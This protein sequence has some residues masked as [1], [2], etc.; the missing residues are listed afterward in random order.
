[1]WI[2]FSRGL[3]GQEV[4]Q[5]VAGGV[6]KPGWAAVRTWARCA[7][8]YGRRRSNRRRTENENVTKCSQR[9][10]REQRGVA[11]TITRHRRERLPDAAAGSPL[12]RHE[13]R[14]AVPHPD[15]VLPFGLGF[16]HPALPASGSGR[17]SRL[18]SRYLSGGYCGGSSG[19]STWCSL[20]AGPGNVEPSSAWGRTTTAAAGSWA[21]RTEDSAT[22]SS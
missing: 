12:R 3:K 21:S 10:E 18:S 20:D 22:C 8:R 6:R 19:L 2:T 15:R 14:N 16:L 17:A 7:K 13:R 1:V 9:R 11:Q 5:G 4:C